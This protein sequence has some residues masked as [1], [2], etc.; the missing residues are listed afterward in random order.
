MKIKEIM[1]RAV[2][3]DKDIKL[4]EAARIMSEKGIGSLI[5][6]LKEKIA[7]IITERDI[8]KNV[9]KVNKKIS[10]AMSRDVITI[11]E[12]ETLDDAASLMAKNKI[13]RLPVVKN[14]KLVGIVTATDIIANASELNEQFFFE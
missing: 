14:N 6:L 4:V 3:V 2:A 5:V 12:D 10:E 7:G 1:K 8:L 9:D 13:K 11:E